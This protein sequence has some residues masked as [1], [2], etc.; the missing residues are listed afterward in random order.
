MSLAVLSAYDNPSFPRC[1]SPYCSC[2]VLGIMKA[3]IRVMRVCSH[4]SA[5]GFSSSVCDS[6]TVHAC[7]YLSNLLVVLRLLSFTCLSRLPSRVS[8]GLAALYRDT[9]TIDAC[10][11]RVSRGLIAL[12]RDTATTDCV[13][14]YRFIVLCCVCCRTFAPIR[15]R[16]AGRRQMAL[17]CHRAR[18]PRSHTSP[19]TRSTAAW[20]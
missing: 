12:Y 7:V 13:T 2:N 20:A 5:S 1:V 15:H 17:R 8:R 14:R 18:S 6:T 11:T 9:A 10:N 4:D 16:A 19:S 3:R